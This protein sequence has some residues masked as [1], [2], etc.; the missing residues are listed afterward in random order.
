MA[1]LKE[2][3]HGMAA[4]LRRSLKGIRARVRSWRLR[5]SAG[6]PSAP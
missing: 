1:K 3:L 2:K 4:T 6:T 5:S